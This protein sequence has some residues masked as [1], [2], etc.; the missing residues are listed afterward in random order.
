MDDGCLMWS[1]AILLLLFVAW[2]FPHI[3][4]YFIFLLSH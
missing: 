4:N 1:I 3:G 2:A